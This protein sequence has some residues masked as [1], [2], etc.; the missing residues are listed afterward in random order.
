MEGTLFNYKMLLKNCISHIISMKYM[1]NSIAGSF[2]LSH[3]QTS[4]TIS[5]TVYQTGFP[6][7]TL[8]IFTCIPESR[9]VSSRG[10][11]Q[12]ESTAS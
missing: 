11:S 3:C 2:Q 5:T 10:N 7:F 4:E 8:P 9:K 6:A 1:I 12:G